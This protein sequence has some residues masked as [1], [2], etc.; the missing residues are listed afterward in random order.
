MSVSGDGH[1]IEVT[2]TGDD[3]SYRVVC[4][5]GGENCE[6]WAECQQSHP[7][8]VGPHPHDKDCEPDCDGEDHAL[9]CDEWLWR[10]GM[11]HG[12]FHQ[13]VGSFLCI[14]DS[15][16]WM[17]DWI[18]EFDEI[19]P[20][21]TPGLYEFDYDETDPDDPGLLYILGMRPVEQTVATAVN[22]T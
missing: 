21:F 1:L 9:E 17:T 8:D 11:M 14:Q 20:N 4:P 3:Q 18:I 19:N 16:C 12:E 13:Y 22:P 7:C 15:G 10:D 2:G 6:C 5:D